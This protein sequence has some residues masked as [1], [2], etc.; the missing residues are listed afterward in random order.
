MWVEVMAEDG[1]KK[2]ERI[3][4]GLAQ[5]TFVLPWLT[6]PPVGVEALGGLVTADGLLSH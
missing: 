2:F 6:E 3:A 5:R 1:G 4:Q